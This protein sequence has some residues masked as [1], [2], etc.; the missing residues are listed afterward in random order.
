MRIDPKALERSK[1]LHRTGARGKA[2][3]VKSVQPKEFSLEGWANVYCSKLFGCY[4]QSVSPTRKEA[5]YVASPARIACIR[6]LIQGREGDG[7]KKGRRQK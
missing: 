2:K 6:V 1:R 4:F 5:N 3:K 7:L